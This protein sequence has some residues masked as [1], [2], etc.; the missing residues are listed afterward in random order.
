[1]GANQKGVSGANATTKASPF[2]S[3][4]HPSHKPAV[5]ALGYFAIALS[6]GR[7]LADGFGE[8]C[9]MKKLLCNF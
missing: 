8:S 5:Y 1:M 3:E 4:I 6:Q 9:V 7:L 2:E